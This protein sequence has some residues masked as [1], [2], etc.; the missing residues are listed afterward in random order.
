MFLPKKETRICR[1]VNIPALSCTFYAREHIN[2]FFFIVRSRSVTMKQVLWSYSCSSAV[3]LILYNTSTVGL[4]SLIHSVRPC[5]CLKKNKTL[6]LNNFR[7]L[8]FLWGYKTAAAAYRGARN[9]SWYEV[10]AGIRLLFS[11]WSSSVAL[12]F[13]PCTCNNQL[14]RRRTET[15]THL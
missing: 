15:N 10:L 14:C 13:Q 9:H 8:S 12:C 7:H 11:L 2:T 1:I 4:Q 5:N 6:S 3:I